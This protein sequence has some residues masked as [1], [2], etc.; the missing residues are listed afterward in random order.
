MSKYSVS[1]NLRNPKF[2]GKNFVSVI[3]KFQFVV[4]HGNTGLPSQQQVDG[5]RNFFVSVAL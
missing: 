5:L 2:K 1:Q 3:G 4:S